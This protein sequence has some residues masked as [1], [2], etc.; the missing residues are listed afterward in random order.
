MCVCVCVFSFGCS[1]SGIF[2][3]SP[4]NFHS[5]APASVPASEFF[6]R[7]KPTFSSL[8]NK[9]HRTARVASTEPC[10]VR[11]SAAINTFFFKFIFTVVVGLALIFPYAGWPSCAKFSIFIPSNKWWN[12]ATK[13][14]PHHIRWVTVMWS[15]H[16]QHCWLNFL[17]I[18]LLPR[19][20]LLAMWCVVWICALLYQLNPLH[21]HLV[22]TAPPLTA[23][24]PV[25]AV[26]T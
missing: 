18:A 10:V 20:W 19:S 14:L 6:A 11:Y 17:I 24:Q 3:G 13:R 5:A 2:K 9:R 7:S 15:R 22:P 8:N 4:S 16:C 12:S 23:L 25:S 21:L 1:D 26:W